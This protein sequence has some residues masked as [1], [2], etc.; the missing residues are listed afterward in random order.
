MRKTKG[1][2][3]RFLAVFMALLLVLSTLS[4]MQAQASD[5]K[6]ATDTFGARFW[7]DEPTI[8]FYINSANRYLLET[9]KSPQFGTTAGEWSVLDLLRGMHLGYDY[10]NHIS[11]DYFDGYISRF[12][13]KISKTLGTSQ[14]IDKNKSTEYSRLML[15][16]GSLGYD[17]KAV[18]VAGDKYDFIEDLSSSF[19]FAK[20]QGINGPIWEVI[21]LN[22]VGYQLYEAEEVRSRLDMLT[23]EEAAA[24]VQDIE[25]Q[26]AALT[27]ASSG[28]SAS[29]DTTELDAQL[30]AAK[31]TLTAVN[32]INTVG[33]MIESLHLVNKLMMVV[34]I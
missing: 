32:D 25:Q 4:P 22:T 7:N 30:K 23:P 33:K 28:D 21:A 5:T 8:G 15:T 1:I 27:A 17:A 29:V 26:I 19:A 24:A 12:E 18:G 14:Y 34:G 9:V 13:Q 11:N 10:I 3:Q 16:L 6:T 31:D 20:K 2:W